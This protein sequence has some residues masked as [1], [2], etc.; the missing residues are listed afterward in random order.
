[1]GALE[2]CPGGEA[3]AGLEQGAKHCCECRHNGLWGRP[4]KTLARL[5]KPEGRCSGYQRFVEGSHAATCV[6]LQEAIALEMVVGVWPYWPNLTVHA[7]R[8]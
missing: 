6:L 3:A 7:G 5:E 4:A 1:M 8:K 2:C